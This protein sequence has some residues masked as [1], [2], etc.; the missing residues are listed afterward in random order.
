MFPRGNATRDCDE[1]SIQPCP[2]E[3]VSNRSPG[4]GCIKAFING[5]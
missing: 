5:G 2:K 3:K 4:A 1:L